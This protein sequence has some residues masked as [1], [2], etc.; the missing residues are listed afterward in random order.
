MIKN[1]MAAGLIALKFTV[2]A[3]AEDQDK[4]YLGFN[5]T[6]ECVVGVI[7]D[8]FGDAADI[9][10]LDKE[11]IGIKDTFSTGDQ[12][13]VFLSPSNGSTAMRTVEEIMFLSN[14]RSTN[15]SNS[16][17]IYSGSDLAPKMSVEAGNIFNLEGNST[18]SQKA[19]QIIKATHSALLN[20]FSLG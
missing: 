10:H 13:S 1:C 17:F 7:K 14:G 12:I 11:I 20:C 6:D 18:Q 5:T 8:I 15:V 4:L 3:L 16:T 9:I 2:P 19:T